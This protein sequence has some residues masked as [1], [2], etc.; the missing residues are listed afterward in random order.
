MFL[1]KIRFLSL[2]T[3][4]QACALFSH[5]M[6]TVACIQLKNCSVLLKPGMHDNE[7]V[8]KGLILYLCLCSIECISACPLY[9]RCR[10][11]EAF[12]FSIHFYHRDLKNVNWSVISHEPSELATRWITHSNFYLNQKNSKINKVFEN[13]WKYF[14][15]FN[16]GTNYNPMNHCKRQYQKW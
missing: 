12:F 11:P 13:D 5:M 1:L 6:S 2:F 7:G 9:Q 8:W 3:H 10:F 4:P 16:E 15:I 14:N